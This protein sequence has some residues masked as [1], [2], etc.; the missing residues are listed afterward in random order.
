[1]HRPQDQRLEGIGLV[2]PQYSPGTA[3]GAVGSRC[4][5]IVAVV[6]GSL[7]EEG[8]AGSFEEGQAE[9]GMDM[10]VVTGLELRQLKPIWQVGWKQERTSSWQSWKRND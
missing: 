3:A 6:A 10:L 9:A 8:Q 4:R 7:E 1:M 5:C 2:P